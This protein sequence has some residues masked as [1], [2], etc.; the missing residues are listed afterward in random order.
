MEKAREALNKEL[1]IIGIVRQLRYFK[2]ASDQLLHKK[3][4]NKLKK[5]SQY[6]FI[7]SDDK[8]TSSETDN[9]E[10]FNSKAKISQHM[11]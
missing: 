1:N 9:L 7:E 10:L 5:Q 4:R 11:Q 2:L 3:T 8:L 6:V